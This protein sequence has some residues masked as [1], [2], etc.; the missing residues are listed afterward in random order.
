VSAEGRVELHLRALL[1]IRS[2]SQAYAADS[3]YAAVG[4][5]AQALRKCEGE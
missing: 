3:N 2:S 5:P 4:V 1:V